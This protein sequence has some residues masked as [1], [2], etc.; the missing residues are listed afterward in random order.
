[1]Y[2]NL[3]D[4][5]KCI[6]CPMECTCTALLGCSVCTPSANRIITLTGAYSVCPCKTGFT[7]NSHGV[8]ECTLPY[9]LNDTGNCVCDPP[10]E[11]VNA[12]CQC[13]SIRAPTQYY[14]DSLANSCY[15]CPEGCIC[16]SIGCVSCGSDALRV[17]ATTSTGKICPCQQ[18]TVFNGDSCTYCSN[19]SMVVNGE[20]VTCTDCATCDILGCRSCNSDATLIDH[21]CVCTNPSYIN[22]NGKCVCSIDKYLN[23][24]SS[25]CVDCPKQCHTC[26]LNSSGLF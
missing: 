21:K 14:Y 17:I 24:S 20:C 18:T 6:M 15:I 23:Q 2:K 9:S 1:M 22:I 8:C 16:S 25:Q 11:L 13:K 7:E 19:N 12:V 10:Y 26:H 3:Q 5:R 4:S